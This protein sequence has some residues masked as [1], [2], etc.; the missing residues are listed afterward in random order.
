MKTVGVDLGTTNTLAALEGRLL[1]ATDSEDDDGIVPSVVAFLPN[2]VTK[3]GAAARRRRAV[4]PK[5]TI[6]SAKR[7]IGRKWHSY[8]VSRFR[9]C[10]P[11]E[12]VKTEAGGAAFRTR[13]GTFAPSQIAAGVMDTVRRRTGLD[14]GAYRALIAV[15]ATF[16]ADQRQATLEAGKEVGFREV[17]VLEEPV[18]TAVAYM[19]ARPGA[20]RRA[21]VYDL[22]GGTFNLAVVDCSA[23]PYRVVGHGG[24]TYLGGD[25]IDR[26]MA[27]W[28]AQ[29]VLAKYRWDLRSDPETYDRLV[30]EAERAK[31]RL[32][33]A[34]QTSLELG[35][36]DPASPVAIE[37]VK[38]DREMLERVAYPLIQRTFG[39]CD[40]V[41]SEAAVRPRDIDA[42]LLAGGSTG[43]AMVRHYVARYFDQTPEVAFDPMEVVALGAS[44]ADR[45]IR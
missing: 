27:E 41:L 40:E 16:G 22:G 20:I 33:F 18:A 25:D 1:R 37:S 6:Y 2:G 44:L 34:R 28:A 32:S 45:E 29:Q 23:R 26:A 31:I 7:I 39:V 19:A 38:L 14:P 13:A 10:Y 24:D 15:P 9:E 30:L 11:F 36:V 21:A 35:Q 43:L 12:L 3:V 4:D 42:V 17:A 5:N 8:E